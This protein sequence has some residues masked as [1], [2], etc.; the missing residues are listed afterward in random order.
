MSK[1]SDLP[2]Y[3]VRSLED[4]KER[5]VHRNLLTPCMFLPVDEDGQKQNKFSTAKSPDIEDG[6]HGLMRTASDEDETSEEEIDI[7]F[8][9]V[10]TTSPSTPSPPVLTPVKIENSPG[11]DILSPSILPP[12]LTPQVCDT[13]NASPSRIHENMTETECTKNGFCKY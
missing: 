1:H 7:A 6:D 4:D 3:T 8:L 13:D 12:K 10:G 2:V 9:P 11:I 5:T